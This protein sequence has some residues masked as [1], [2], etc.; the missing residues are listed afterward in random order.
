MRGVPF[1]VLPRAGPDLVSP[2][3]AAPPGGSGSC[4]FL[5]RCVFAGV[6]PN[7]KTPDPALFPPF[8][9]DSCRGPEQYRDITPAAAGVPT[10]EISRAAGPGGTG[11][12]RES[13]PPQEHDNKHDDHNEDDGSN[14]DKHR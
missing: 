4:P 11:G 1:L 7:V 5:G 13:V 3:P 9:G 12:W 6:G 10:G 8:R 14:A 2:A